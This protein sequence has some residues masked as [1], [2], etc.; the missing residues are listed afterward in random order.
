MVDVGDFDSKFCSGPEAYEQGRV[1]A[2]LLPRNRIRDDL[3]GFVMI[4][5]RQPGVTANLSVNYLRPIPVGMH[6][7]AEA[8]MTRIDGRKMFAE[9]V[10]FDDQGERVPLRGIT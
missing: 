4:A 10:A 3:I 1:L 8:W 2:A 9:S 5:H 7:R 6:L